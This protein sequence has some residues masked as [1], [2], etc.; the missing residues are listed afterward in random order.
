MQITLRI[1]EMHDAKRLNSA[2]QRLSDDLNDEHTAQ[3]EDLARVGWANVPGFR[4]VLAETDEVVG[5][6]LYSPVFS[7]TRGGAG[8]FVSD[9]WAAPKVRGERLGT[10]LLS[11]ALA[12]GRALWNAN[13]IKLSVYEGNRNAWRFYDRMGF[14]PLHGQSELFLDKAGCAALR[15]EV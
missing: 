5:V 6:A 4:A 3:A 9:L 2:L 13:F 8:L 15:G 12:D 11:A 7:T 14:E 1:A 10:R